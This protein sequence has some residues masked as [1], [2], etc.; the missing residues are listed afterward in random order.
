MRFNRL[1]TASIKPLTAEL[2]DVSKLQ[3]LNEKKVEELLYLLVFVWI[4]E[5]KYY[6]GRTDMK[7]KN[8]KSI[9]MCPWM[10]FLD[11]Q[12]LYYFGLLV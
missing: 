2:K 1:Q 3:Y 8:C 10:H 11:L 5:V 9:G 6:L 4:L 12:H 7:N